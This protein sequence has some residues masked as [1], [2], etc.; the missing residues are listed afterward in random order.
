MYSFTNTTT[1]MYFCNKWMKEPN[2]FF[3]TFAYFY[4]IIKKSKYKC[5]DYEWKWKVLFARA[6][7]LEEET[8]DVINTIP[9]IKAL[10]IH[11]MT[12][13]INLKLTTHLS[14]PKRYSQ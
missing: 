13:Y 5:T 2:F 8:H 14:I 11:L 3:P 1:R 12:Y 10:Y 9:E 4:D 7:L 6:L